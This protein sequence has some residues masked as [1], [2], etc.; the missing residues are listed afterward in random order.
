M[1]RVAK[2]KRNVRDRGIHQKYLNYKQEVIEKLRSALNYDGLVVQTINLD[3]E[4]V[5]TYKEEIRATLEGE[6]EPSEFIKSHET[7]QKQKKMLRSGGLVVKQW[8]K[9]VLHEYEAEDITL[10]NPELLVV[11]LHGMIIDLETKNGVNTTTVSKYSKLPNNMTSFYVNLLDTDNFLDTIL[12]IVPL[13]KVGNTHQVEGDTYYLISDDYLMKYL[14]ETSLSSYSSSIELLG[15]LDNI[16]KEDNDFIKPNKLYLEERKAILDINASEEQFLIDVEAEKKVLFLVAG[17]FKKVEGVLNFS[18]HYEGRISIPNEKEQKD[19]LKIFHKLKD[20]TL[21]MELERELEEQAKLE[22]QAQQEQ[23]SSVVVNNRDT[24][25]T[26]STPLVEPYRKPKNKPTYSSVKL[27]PNEYG[28]KSFSRLDGLEMVQEGIY[29]R[30][31][32]SKVMARLHYFSGVFKQASKEYYIPYVEDINKGLDMLQEYGKVAV[33]LTGKQANRWGSN[34]VYFSLTESEIGSTLLSV[35]KVQPIR[36]NSV[37]VTEGVYDVEPF[38][39]EEDFQAYYSALKADKGPDWIPEVGFLPVEDSHLYTISEELMVFNIQEKVINPD[40]VGNGLFEEFSTYRELLDRV[41]LLEYEFKNADSVFIDTMGYVP[42]GQALT[43][44]TLRLLR[45][46]PFGLGDTY[47]DTYAMYNYDTSVVDFFALVATDFTEKEQELLDTYFKEI[48]LERQRLRGVATEVLDNPN[49]TELPFSG[50][51]V[52]KEEQKLHNEEMLFNPKVNDTELQY[53]NTQLGQE[54]DIY[55]G[56][57]GIRGT[58]E[59]NNYILAGEDKLAQN[60]EE[61]HTFVDKFIEEKYNDIQYSNDEISAMRERVKEKYQMKDT[62]IDKV[63]SD[64]ELLHNLD[65]LKQHVYL[66]KDKEHVFTDTVTQRY[67]QEEPDTS[68]KRLA[69]DNEELRKVYEAYNYHVQKKR[70]LSSG[71][72]TNLFNTEQDILIVD[73]KGLHTTQ[74]TTKRDVLLGGI[75]LRAL[76]DGWYDNL[77]QANQRRGKGIKGVLDVPPVLRNKYYTK[78]ILE[79][80]L[81]KV[82]HYAPKDKDNTKGVLE[83]LLSGDI[84]KDKEQLDSIQFESNSSFKSIYELPNIEAL[85]Y[86]QWNLLLL[87]SQGKAPVSLVT[88]TFTVSQLLQS[89]LDDMVV[90]S[91][92]GSPTLKVYNNA[93]FE[94]IIPEGGLKE[95]NS[96]TYPFEIDYT[97]VLDNTTHLYQLHISIKEGYY[98]LEVVLQEING[99]SVHDYNGIEDDIYGNEETE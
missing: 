73:N 91:A 59:F 48:N 77:Y 70:A 64:I 19:K 97:G 16:F 8:D 20:G 11:D 31:L 84:L 78:R 44:K 21:I 27:N 28:L 43:Y 60:A 66:G 79:T 82:L 81:D 69:V 40:Y 52:D 32:H 57:I 14:E 22:Q 46:T 93:I 34:L 45:L 36:V 30:K 61:V 71:V 90:E 42:V 39:S 88:E 98:V 74:Y 76:Q 68:R 56:G 51:E 6:V 3:N 35:Q 63:A 18:H 55:I 54:S 92:C 99:H 12:M 41:Y 1:T 89:L 80:E 26:S 25:N 83:S 86:G 50:N 85:S 38:G 17:K 47:D 58:D 23:R 7:Y 15:V 13:K 5:L 53:A 94:G 72:L 37:N 87:Y 10:D 29:L 67:G 65:G 49:D 75:H 9:G 33:Y 95:G 4:D 2:E 96:I 24:G 62:E